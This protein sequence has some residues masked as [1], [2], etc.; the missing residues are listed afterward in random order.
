[1]EGRDP[2]LVVMKGNRYEL[3]DNVREGWSEE[4]FR[5]RYTDILH[6]YDYIVGDWGYSQLRL[7]GFF[8]DANPKANFDSKISALPEYIYEFCNFGCAYFVLKKIK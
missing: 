2:S 5:E 4:Q 3:I 1:M 8:A 7:R 6:K